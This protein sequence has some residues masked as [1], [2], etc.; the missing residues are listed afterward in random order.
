MSRVDVARG[1]E[2]AVLHASTQILGFARAQGD[3][4]ETDAAAWWVVVGE[5]DGVVGVVLVVVSSGWA[6]YV[7]GM[8]DVLGSLPEGQR[9]LD[10]SSWPHGRAQTRRSQLIDVVLLEEGILYDD[11]ARILMLS[12]YG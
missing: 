11:T 10:S 7:K 8:E 5:E 12:D 6:V 1:G 9:K 2:V 4:G 3:G